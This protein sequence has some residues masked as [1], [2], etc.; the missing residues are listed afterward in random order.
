MIERVGLGDVFGTGADDGGDFDFPV[1]LGRTA[2]LSTLSFGR[3]ARIVAF[4]KIGSGGMGCRFP[5][6]GRHSWGDGDEF[7]DAGDRR[8]KARRVDGGEL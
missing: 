7:G 4:R 5:W 1:E 3:L 6:R 8:A 2:R